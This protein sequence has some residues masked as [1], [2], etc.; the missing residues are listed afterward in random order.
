MVERAAA[1][2]AL[3]G[4]TIDVIALAAVRATREAQM[5]RAGELLPSIIGVPAEGE[6][7]GGTTF[8]GVAEAAMFPGDLPTDPEA[9]FRPDGA[10]FRGLTAVAP[11]DADFRF[12]RLRP[13]S[14]NSPMTACRRCPIFGLIARCSS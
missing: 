8:D 3:T 13:P 11:E 12:L 1:R 14:S 5:R 4:A 9:L 7:A 6:H 2:A 10:G